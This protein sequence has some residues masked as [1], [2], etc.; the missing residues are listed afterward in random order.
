MKETV[1]DLQCFIP[2]SEI[3]D[4]DDYDEDYDYDEAIEVKGFNFQIFNFVE[5]KIIWKLCG[6]P[7]TDDT[8]GK[9]VSGGI[10][11]GGIV[12]DLNEVR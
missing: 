12:L 9:V 2:G 7:Y 1:D 10:E 3:D 5:K 8:T 6:K 4:L 11:V